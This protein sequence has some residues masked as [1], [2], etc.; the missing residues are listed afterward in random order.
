MIITPWPSGIYSRY[1]NLVQ[2]QIPTTLIH[3]A[4]KLKEKNHTILSIDTEK[5][6]DKLQEPLL[7]IMLS[8][9]GRD[10]IP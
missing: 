6:F 4:N 9:T 10:E 3:Y 1:T 5:I 8:E 2:Y 7:V